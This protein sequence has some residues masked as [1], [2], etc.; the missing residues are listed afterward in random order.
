MLGHKHEQN[1]KLKEELLTDHE[2]DHLQRKHLELKHFEKSLIETSVTE[3]K[4]D[5][6]IEKVVDAVAE[7]EALPKTSF[8][9]LTDKPKKK[10]T[11]PPKAE[12]KPLKTPMNDLKE[13]APV[14]EYIRVASAESA[15][16]GTDGLPVTPY[17]DTLMK[18]VHM[19]HMNKERLLKDIK[20]NRVMPIWE[21]AKEEQ[22]NKNNMKR[23][24][25]RTSPTGRLRQ[26]GRTNMDVIDCT[27]CRY[28]WLKVEQDLGNSREYHQLYDVFVQHCAQAQETQIF[29]HACNKMFGKI[30]RM[31]VDYVL[32][33]TVNQMCMK[34]EM[35]R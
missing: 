14:S 12:I 23:F 25:R 2:L 8:I 1:A 6:E 29:F 27:A 20:E 7:G 35:C 34:A 26:Q 31:I 4:Q 13:K 33:H 16:L 17:T 3:E 30:D 21:L 22:R 32:G 18:Q 19:L 9:S 5:E 28:I 24:V 15:K 11:G 10:L